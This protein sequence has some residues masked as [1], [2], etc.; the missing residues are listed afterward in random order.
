MSRRASGP[1][2]IVG[3]SA[4]AA[5]MSAIRAGFEPWGIDLFGDRDFRD[6]ASVRVCPMD[7]YPHG[8]P[9]IAR[10]WPELPKR[11]PLLLAG[12]MENHLQ[13]VAKLAEDHPLLA[14]SVS[15]IA[16][17][18][19]GNLWR[20]WPDMPGLRYP[21]PGEEK[22]FGQ[23]W[24]RKPRFSGGGRNIDRSPTMSCQTGD[25]VYLQAFVPG[26]PVSA[27][28]AHESFPIPALPATGRCLLGITQQLIGD[29]RLGTQGFI[30]CGNVAPLALSENQQA[31]LERLGH[32]IMRTTGLRSIFGV[33]LILGGDGTLWPIE[34]NPRYTASVE[35]IERLAYWPA[36]AKGIHHARQNAMVP[37]LSAVVLDHAA[38][39]D[40]PAAGD[41]IPQGRPV[42]SILAHGDDPDQ[43]MNH[44][45]QAAQTID[46]SLHFPS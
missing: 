39:A 43:A 11:A 35:V 37:D 33:D 1:L 5:A 30:F 26:R 6:I 40:I 8:I 16:K 23:G 13:V 3:A 14:S 21:W 7:Q 22:A 31:L 41:F 25:E 4:R 18:R 32:W 38:V 29:R 42:C 10:S 34:I 44:L 45:Y 24:M 28:Y 36:A 15:A 27:I 17:A 19:D 12:A 20:F 2:L 46:R 9:A